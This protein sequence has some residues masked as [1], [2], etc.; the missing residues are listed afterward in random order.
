ML[1]LRE[2][3]AIDVKS[4]RLPDLQAGLLNRF[5]AVVTTQED[6]CQLTVARQNGIKSECTDY[7]AI[8]PFAIF[9]GSF[10]CTSSEMVCHWPRIN[11]ILLR[12][13]EVPN[14][15]SLH[16]MFLPSHREVGDGM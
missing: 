8:T 10:I 11:E 7:T 5:H 16:R 12:W 13:I 9:A 15:S 4:I 1:Y 6:K 3:H 2:E 14:P